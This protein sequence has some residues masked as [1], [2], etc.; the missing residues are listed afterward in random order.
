MTKLRW[1]KAL[2][3]SKDKDDVRGVIAVQGDSLDWDYI[4]R[5]CD[6]HGT[7]ELLEAVWASI[8]PI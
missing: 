8:P 4:R 3:R 5:W 1:Y 2:N 6:M 7:R